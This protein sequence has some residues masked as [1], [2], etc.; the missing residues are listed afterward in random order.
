[1]LEEV[2]ND[3]KEDREGFKRER[4]RERKKYGEGSSLREGERERM[5]SHAPI[6]IEMI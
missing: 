1:M 4:E 2:E 5:S 6:T 3:I